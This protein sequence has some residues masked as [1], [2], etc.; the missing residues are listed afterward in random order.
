MLAGISGSSIGDV[1]TTE[2]NL[3]TNPDSVRG[4]DLLEDRLR[5][6]DPVTET[7]IVQS[8]TLTVDDAEFQA[9]VEE[10][11]T[12]LLAL[13]GFVD[14][15]TNYY[16][17]ENE[18][19]VSE[20][21]RTTLIPVTLAVEFDD[22]VDGIHNFIDIVHEQDGDGFLVITVGDASASETFNTMAEE[23]LLRVRSSGSSLR[24]S[25]SS[26]SSAHWLRPGC[27]SSWLLSLS[28]SRWA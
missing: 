15:A 20:D 16:E 18:G 8:E 1:L 9:R 21:R 23:D 11:T 7:V 22:A 19:L 14:F 2:A 24:R 17:N 6:P 27:R 4:A 3:T 25:F 5:G 26:S 13:E 12:G 10:T 28:S